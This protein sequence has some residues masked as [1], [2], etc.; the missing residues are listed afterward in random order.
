[1]IL[2]FLNTVKLIFSGKRLTPYILYTT[3][4]VSLFPT[5]ADIAEPVIV[6][7]KSR[8]T[9]QVFRRSLAANETFYGNTHIVIYH[10]GRHALYFL[11]EIT[12]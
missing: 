7:V 6:P 8:H 12:V 3:L 4:H 2:G 9:Q 10:K 1:M 11:E 5:G